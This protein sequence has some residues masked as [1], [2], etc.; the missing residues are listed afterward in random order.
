MLSPSMSTD[1]SIDA[2]SPFAARQRIVTA[3]QRAVAAFLRGDAIA[4]RENERT[5]KDTGYRKLEVNAELA[6]FEQ[7]LEN[8]AR[9]N[10]TVIDVV[11]DLLATDQIF[12]PKEPARI[13]TLFEHVERLRTCKGRKDRARGKLFDEDNFDL[14]QLPRQRLHEAVRWDRFLDA[15]VTYAGEQLAVFTG[16]ASGLAL[17]SNDASRVDVILGEL[18]QLSPRRSVKASWGGEQVRQSR[19]VGLHVVSQALLDRSELFGGKGLGYY[20]QAI[21]EESRRD[22]AEQL[23][24]DRNRLGLRS[25]SDQKRAKL[26]RRSTE[27]DHRTARSEG[28]SPE[29]ILIAAEM[30]RSA[31]SVSAAFRGTLSGDLLT[32]FDEVMTGEYETLTEARETLGFRPSTEN[33][34]RNRAG[35][36]GRKRAAQS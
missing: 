3:L 13:R 7:E 8:L 17:L 12:E 21:C 18:F 26:N 31:E 6:A 1:Q 19:H 11:R 36:F 30:D 5:P 4:R 10:Q 2:K 16:I 23:A 24:M 33:S 20:A 35:R 9:A 14:E 25:V 15:A 34:L 28:P 22:A 29:E 32:L 27:P